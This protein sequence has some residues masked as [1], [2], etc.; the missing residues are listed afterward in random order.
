MVMYHILK[1]IP[2]NLLELILIALKDVVSKKKATLSY[3]MAL[4][5]VFKLVGIRFKGDD[6]CELR[7]TNIYNESS[8]DQC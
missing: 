8:L 3:G 7:Y 2:I 4:T 1:K 6:S 5:N